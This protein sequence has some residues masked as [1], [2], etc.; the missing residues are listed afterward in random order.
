MYIIY[1]ETYLSMAQECEKAI[2]YTNVRNMDV[3][4]LFIFLG[5]LLLYTPTAGQ[6]LL[7]CLSYLFVILSL[8]VIDFIYNHNTL[9]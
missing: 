1:G 8:V 5:C 4:F 6:L 2:E 9:S 7:F 3:N